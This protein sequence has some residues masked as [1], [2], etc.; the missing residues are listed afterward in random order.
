MYLDK[1]I[2]EV[3]C[4]HSAS[5]IWQNLST[6]VIVSESLVRDYD[7][8]NGFGSVQE[9]SFRVSDGYCSCVVITHISL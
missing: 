8:N 2:M 9:R 5:M 4:N 3:V 7:R 6:V 1:T